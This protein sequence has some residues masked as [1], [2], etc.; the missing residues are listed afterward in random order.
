VTGVKWTVA[1]L[2]LAFVLAGCSASARPLPAVTSTTTTTLAPSA[3]ATA[4]IDPGP[5]TT[6]AG[7][8]PYIAQPAVADALGIRLGTQSVQSAGGAPVG[9]KFFAT[10]D[11]AFVASE[12]LPGP[13]Q[14]VLQITSARYSSATAAHN[15][16][17]A[18]GTS[19]ANAPGS[20]HSATIAGGIVGVAFQT[21]FDPSDGNQD[22][23]FVF[24]TGATVVTVLTAQ[25]DS[26][27]D[28][29]VVAGQIAPKF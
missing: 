7:T 23:A 18:I 16:M 22:W 20:A 25:A 14:P 1:V 26:E 21:T 24:S 4:A 5:T 17:V 3:P 8:C 27:L 2:G 6:A 10:T 13:D 15:A 19:T 11:P 28:A 29:Q 12:H 9:C